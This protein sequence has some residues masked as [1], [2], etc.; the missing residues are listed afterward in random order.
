MDTLQDPVESATAA[1]RAAGGRGTRDSVVWWGTLVVAIAAI[2]FVFRD[3]L[4]YMVGD[5]DK[6]EYSHGFLIPIIAA[7]LI[8]RKKDDLAAAGVLAPGGTGAALPGR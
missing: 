6:E 4:V 2:A 7:F 8:W 1:S 3:G 5:W